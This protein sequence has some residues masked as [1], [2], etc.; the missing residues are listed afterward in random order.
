MGESEDIN[1]WLTTRGRLLGDGVA[2]VEGYAARLVQAGVPLSR[3]NIAQRFANPLLA[4]WGMIWKP[5]STTQ[6]DVT[7]SILNTASYIGGPFEYVLTNRVTLHKSLIGLD[8]QTEHSAYIELADSGG[9]DLFAN[10]LE[11][12]D[13][14]VQGCTYVSNDPQGFR[15]SH[16]ELIQSTRHGLACALEPVAMRKSM[17][18]LLRTYLGDGPA[19]AV[20]EGTI[21]RGA[22]TALEAVVMFTDLRGFTHKSETWSEA[23][24]LAALNGY[25][26]VVV[27]AVE[28]N[29]GDV[30]KFIGDGILSVFPIGGE[31]SSEDQCRSAIDATRAA[32]AGMEELNK[33]REKTGEEALSVGIGIN[34]GPVTYGNIGSPARLDFTVL[35]SAVNVAS[36]VQDLCKTI[37]EPAL[38]TASVASYWPAEFSLKGSHAVRG[39]AEPIEVFALNGT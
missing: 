35:G 23:T 4:A 22:H 6:Y 14:S 9:T 31:S 38:A 28:A 36:R 33:E 29:S 37:G 11:Y 32:F 17:A 39:V 20:R 13:G 3:A 25:F 34:R 16:L 10:W 26:D 8:R 21:Q 7:R 2:I 1:S 12:G 15:D 27:Q 18:S 30:L 24:L 19:L 5:E